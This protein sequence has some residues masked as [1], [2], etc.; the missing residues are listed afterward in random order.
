MP[1]TQRSLKGLAWHGAVGVVLLG[2]IQA[3]SAVEPVS[4]SVSPAAGAAPS[5]SLQALPQAAP[6]LGNW[7]FRHIDTNHDGKLSREEAAQ[8]PHLVRHFDEI[9]VDHDGFISPEEKCNAWKVRIAALER[10]K[11]LK[12]AAS[13]VAAAASR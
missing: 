4:P 7:R 11:S 3:A 5:G 6:D 2:L 13:A 8:E 9:D 10:Q 1:D 12:A